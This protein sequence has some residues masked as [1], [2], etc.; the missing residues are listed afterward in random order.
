[1]KFNKVYIEITNICGLKCSFCPPSERKNDTMKLS[2]FEDICSQAKV[3]TK[4]IY[5]HI[6]GDPL[7]LSNLSEYIDIAKKHGL[8]V[9]ITTSGFFLDSSKYKMLICNNIKQI[10]FSLN[11]FN[12]NST[13]L[14]LNDYLTPIFEFAKFK[15]K[16]GNKQFVNFRIWNIDNIDDIEFNKILI[17]KINEFFNS[18]IN[19]E[20][21][22]ATKPK[23]IRIEDKVLLNFDDYFEWPSLEN[24]VVGEKGFCY[25]LNSHIGILSNGSVVPCCLDKNAD[26]NLGNIFDTPLKSILNGRKTQNIIK[27]FKEKK[28]VEELCQKCSF[29]TRFES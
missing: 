23:K 22:Y 10:N 12:A 5:L 25:G 16:N 27:G 4:E 7:V 15:I 17:T 11:S 21:I 28:V 2:S 24:N 14:N 19:I 8:I 13:N 20:E 6:I 29:R 26:I 3:Y 1:M 18:N 9:N